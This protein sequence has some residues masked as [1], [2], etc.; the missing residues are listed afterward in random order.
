MIRIAF[1]VCEV[2]VHD[3]F[4]TRGADLVQIPT[5][6]TQHEVLGAVVVDAGIT[7][8]TCAA[9]TP[10]SIISTGFAF[11]LGGTGTLPVRAGLV[12]R[13]FSTGSATAV[14]STDLAI[15]LDIATSLGERTSGAI[16]IATIIE[17]HTSWIALT[18]GI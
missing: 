2:G 14:V 3:A 12:L 10:T 18:D 8:I 6:L 16:I 11:A 15:T 7:G 9:G 1:G 5:T 4:A 17:L 13:A